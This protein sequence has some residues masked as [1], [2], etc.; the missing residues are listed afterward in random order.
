MSLMQR[1]YVASMMQVIA[2]GSAPASRTYLVD[3]LTES[4]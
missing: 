2:R 1:A 3:Y 4:K